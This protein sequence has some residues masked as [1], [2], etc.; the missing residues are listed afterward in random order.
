MMCPIKRNRARS[1]VTAREMC[2]NARFF[3]TRLN[4]HPRLLSTGAKSWIIAEGSVLKHSYISLV[5]WWWTASGTW[6]RP[7]GGSYTFMHLADGVNPSDISMC[8]ELTINN[9]LYFHQIHLCAFR[10]LENINVT[11][12]CLMMILW[13]LKAEGGR[14]N[15]ILHFSAKEQK[16]HSEDEWHIGELLL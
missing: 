4:C 3:Q 1:S 14:K 16:S 9:K 8:I 6:R 15:E 10:T 2:W 13:P 11:C 7:G 5:H 12:S